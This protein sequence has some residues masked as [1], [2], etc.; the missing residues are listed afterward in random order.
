MIAGSSGSQ[1]PSSCDTNLVLNNNLTGFDTNSSSTKGEHL[2]IMKI[3]DISN[4]IRKLV[5]SKG[6]TGFGIAISEDKYHRLIVRGLNPN[7]VAFSVSF[8]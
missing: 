1:S 2:N 5:I 7:G 3:E 8:F 4:P 6:P